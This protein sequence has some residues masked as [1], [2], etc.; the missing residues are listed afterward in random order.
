MVFEGA[1]VVVTGANG[2]GKTNL[3]E[4]IYLTSALRSFRQASRSSLIRFGARAAN[5][6]VTVEGAASDGFMA[7][8]DGAQT[9][10]ATTRLALEFT[11]EGRRQS[12]DGDAETAPHGFVG[13]LSCLAFTPTDLALTS[14]GAEGRRRALDRG[15]F[16]LHPVYLG[17]LR[18]FAHVLKGRNALLKS[19]GGLADDGVL[20]AWDE[21]LAETGARVVMRRAEWLERLDARMGGLYRAMTG[22]GEAMSLLYAADGVR[23]GDVAGGEEAVRERLLSVLQKRRSDDREKRVTVQ[24][25]HRDDVT[26]LMDGRPL[27]EIASQGQRRSFVLALKAAEI[28]EVRA[29]RGVS[30][31]LLLDDVVSELDPSR[32]QALLDFVVQTPSQVIVTATDWD[33]AELLPRGRVQRFLVAGGE[34]T[35]RGVHTAS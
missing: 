24:G 25:P 7:A 26:F 2:Q 32:R 4:A 21:Q 12:V 10:M 20:D 3:I 19:R 11:S 35:E 17:E 16:A 34:V 23:A 27:R 8:P 9:G 33:A 13:R 14:G 28:D 18:R 1:T 6:A 30:P 15:V 22:S 31:V 29:Q 5:V